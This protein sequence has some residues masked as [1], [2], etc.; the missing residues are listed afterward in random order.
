MNNLRIISALLIGLMM[1][2]CTVAQP[3]PAA[4]LAPTPSP[5]IT[6]TP[7]PARL[8]EGKIIFEKSSDKKFAGTVHGQGETAIIMANMSA[9]TDIQW[10][11]F[12]DA[13]DKQNFTTITFNYLRADATSASQETRIVL[14]KLRESGYKR[15]ICIGASL[16]VTSC[17]SIAG[18]PEIVGLVL[19][20]GPNNGGSLAKVTYPKLFI[21]GALDRWARDTQ[22]AYDKAAEPKKLVLFEE[23]SLHGSGLFYSK[24]SEEFLTLLIDFVNS[25]A[26]P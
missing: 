3:I 22:V 21:A 24:D 10:A 23:N 18:E 9:G 1:V 8:P 14:R 17:G 19:I 7:T 16:G 5:T 11:P 6:F 4:T 26:N 13:V 12:V 2:S 15:V 20:A 25:L